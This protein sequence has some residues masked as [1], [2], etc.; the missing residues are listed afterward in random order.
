[1]DMDIAN[2]GENQDNRRRAAQLDEALEVLVGRGVPN[3]SSTPG[4]ISRSARRL[5]YPDPFSSRGFQSGSAAGPTK[6][7]SNV[8]RVG[9][10]LACT[11][12]LRRVVSMPGNWK[13]MRCADSSSSWKAAAGTQL[14]LTLWLARCAS[15]DWE[16]E[17]NLI[18]SVA[19]PVQRG[20]S[21]GSLPTILA[22]C[23][24]RS[25]TAH[26]ELTERYT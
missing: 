1:M 13:P 22:K 6:V 17:R 12:Q 5:S 15:P 20:G 25:N 14:G 8:P 18:R 16:Q 11:G 21:N 9:T 7:R 24:A 26:S 23:G 10:A 19:R 4:S 3:R 2:F